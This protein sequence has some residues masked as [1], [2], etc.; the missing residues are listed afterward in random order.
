MITP[1]SQRVNMSVGECTM[2]TV[3]SLLLSGF[4]SDLDL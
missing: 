2:Y 4:V 3:V 1:G